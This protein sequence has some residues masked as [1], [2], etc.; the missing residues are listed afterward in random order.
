M[1]AATR[2][3]ELDLAELDD[4]WSPDGA[5]A[6]TRPGLAPPAPGSAPMPGGPSR[7]PSSP[8]SGRRASG[9]HPVARP[10]DLDREIV[11]QQDAF[12]AALIDEYEARLRE[13]EVRL[14][15][16]RAEPASGATPTTS[17]PR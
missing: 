2:E 12:I 3:L 4:R 7:R 15:S 14:A 16:L 10:R 8:P 17:G 6:H 13:L 1:S 11:E 9:V 5:S